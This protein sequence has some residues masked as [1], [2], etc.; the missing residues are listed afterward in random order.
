MLA[1]HGRLEGW[2]DEKAIDQRR[3][4]GVS[5]NAFTGFSVDSSLLVSQAH[6]TQLT[7]W[8]CKSKSILEYKAAAID[9]LCIFKLAFYGIVTGGE[10]S[11]NAELGACSWEIC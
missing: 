6:C 4:V 7:A 11:R 3:S 10:G 8:S 5:G 9:V 2:I 1:A